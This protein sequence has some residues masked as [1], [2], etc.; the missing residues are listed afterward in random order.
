MA[1]LD[2]VSI[3]ILLGAV[4]VMAGILS[5]LLALRFGAPLL[6]VFLLIGM[7]AGDSG[8]GPAAVRRC[9]HHLS[10]GIGGAGADPVR[11]RLA[12]AFP[13]HQRGAG[14]V[15]GAGDGRRVADGADHRAGRQICAR[16]ELDRGAAGRRRGRLDRR[17]GGVSAGACAGLAVAPARRRDA[18]G[19]IRHQRSVRGVSHADAGRADFG[20]RQLVRACRGGIRPRGRAGRGRRRRRRP[21]RGA[22]AQP[23]GA[24]AG[25]ARAVRAHRG[26]GDLRRR[27]DRARLGVSRG[28]SRRHHHRQPADPRA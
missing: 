3:A 15:D 23:R 1:S 22:G 12:N 26:A 17:G 4:L 25:P 13:E 21:A 9:A 2:S 14:A 19:G 8:P 20:R 10:G 16:P 28:L 5:S 27:A 24:A 6:L 18:G 11:W 7:M